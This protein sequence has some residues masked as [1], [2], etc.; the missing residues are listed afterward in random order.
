[1]KRAC[2][3]NVNLHE[4][5]TCEFHPTIKIKNYLRMKI[6]YIIL[7]TLGFM[8][9]LTRCVS[10][11]EPKG[12]TV[13][14]LLVIEGDMVLND[15]TVITLSRSASIAST[16]KKQY[17]YGATVYIKDTEGRTYNASPK[18]V[19]GVLTYVIPTSSLDLNTTTNYKLIVNTPGGG[20]Y[21]SDYIPVLET[22]DIDEITYEVDSVHQTATFYVSSKSSENLSNYYRWDYSEDWEFTSKYSTFLYYDSKKKQIIDSL[23]PWYYCYKKAAST[24]IYVANTTAL[25]DNRVYK[26]PLATIYKNDDRLSLLYS[27]EVTQRSLTREGYL[28]WENLS[29]NSSD[30]GG[31][32]SPQPSEMKGNLTCVSNP[33]EVVLGFISAVIQKKKRIFAYAKDISLFESD[34]DCSLIE[35]ALPYEEMKKNGYEIVAFDDMSN[36]SFWAM[37]KCVDCRV[38]GTKLRPSFWPLH[39]N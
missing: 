28:Y 22:S 36:A 20:M 37:K 15:T 6:T 25:S 12:A 17:V 18:I 4:N 26:K 23:V 30:L 27:M 8:L 2:S 19:S 9:T 7:L 1:M 31:I 35:A 33:D 21:E 32:F 11:F 29:K 5:N 24:G 39:H 14:G 16:E 38:S 3:K 34:D 10:P 13:E